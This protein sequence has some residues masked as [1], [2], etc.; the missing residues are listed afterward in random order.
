MAPIARLA[1]DLW[2]EVEVVS[3][4]MVRRRQRN[5]HPARPCREEKDP[6]LAILRLEAVDKA[7]SLHCGGAAVESAPLDAAQSQ[8]HGG[9]GRQQILQN[10]KYASPLAEEQNA[11]PLSL[12]LWEHRLEVAHFG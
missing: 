2:V 5:P 11:M 4:D 12:Q 6:G 7:L 3:N 1:I 8:P 10:I 9:G